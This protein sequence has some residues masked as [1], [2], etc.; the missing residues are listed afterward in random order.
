MPAQR[1]NICLFTSCFGHGGTE[2]Q[3]AQIVTRID[4]D[5]Y[6][7]VVACQR[8]YGHYYPYV[9]QAG[10]RV[11]EFPVDG[12]SVRTA[13][14]ACRWMR[15][16]RRQRIDL[17]HTFDLYTNLFAAPF[18]RLAG[19][20]VVITSRRDLGVMWSGLRARAQKRVFQWSDCVVANSAAAAKTLIAQERV[21]A[22]RVWVV[23]NGVDLQLFCSNGHRALT[24]RQLGHGEET[25]L[26][27]VL[28][29]L[30]PE[31]DHITLFEAVPAIVAAFPRVHFLVIGEGP[32]EQQLRRYVQEKRIA[33][34]VSFLGHREDT[35]QLLDAADIVTL[36]TSSES[37]PNVLLEAMSASRPVIASAVG[38][39]LEIVR[40]GETGMLVEPANPQ[41]LSQTLLSLL[42]DPA[43]RERLGR[44]ARRHM[45]QNFDLETA[46]RNLEKVYDRMLARKKRRSL[47]A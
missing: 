46:A 33:A 23:R 29:N 36:P 9:C 21:P 37:L 38:G 42:R 24:R 25:L 10:V 12:A 14:S 8:T 5:R 6:N 39:C 32:R 35:P 4:Q 27:A 16:L 17:V 1:P 47:A 13:R 7:L 41:V 11:V 44:A 30:R 3:F 22:E 34:H 43:R 15:F 18:A 28:A 40:Q 31:K 26:V 45:E 19:V 2:N 20:P